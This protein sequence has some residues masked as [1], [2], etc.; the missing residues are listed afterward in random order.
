MMAS[1]QD[2]AERISRTEQRFAVGLLVLASG[3][4]VR[5]LGAGTSDNDIRLQAIWVLVY[6]IVGHLLLRT[7]T[8][9]KPTRVP[10]GIA[11]FGTIAVLSALW[12]ADPS[13]TIRRSFALLGTGLCAYYLA[14]RFSI[15]DLLKLVVTSCVVAAFITVTYSAIAGRAAYQE[16]SNLLRGAFIH[17]NSLGLTMSIGVLAA[18]MLI[19]PLR[20]I[21][22]R[23]L[24]PAVVFMGT[25][26]VVSGSKT[27]LMSLI[28]AVI[29]L[30][31]ASLHHSAD[32]S[33]LGS[34]LT[35][36]ALSAAVVTYQAIGGLDKFF[37]LLGRDETFT[38][39]SQLWHEVG[40]VIMQRPITGFGYNAFWDAASPAG[41]IR[42]VIGWS[43]THAHS[44]VREVLLEIGVVGLL[45]IMASM[46]GFA[47]LGLR[48][49]F[50]SE[51]AK[52]AVCL[53]FL[54][55]VIVEDLTE[56]VFPTS[57]SLTT[58]LFVAFYVRLQSINAGADE[59]A[60][61]LRTKSA[62]GCR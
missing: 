58:I 8:T 18:T 62:N 52:G 23:R 4:P 24:G 38:G 11:M 55:F 61:T 50:G 32:R 27:A 3:A 31:L 56:S 15:R 37:A 54:T 41:D 21:S 40:K 25:L 30:V 29:A 46:I 35:F 9:A 42:S 45:A 51:W 7:R 26:L 60:L 5:V 53:S 33:M 17:K 34:G 44:G 36:I 49:I 2:A 20:T 19:G 48:R 43:P 14:S 39:R 59:P 47:Y 1:N 57:N 16:G 10:L 22:L 13:L 6:V 12:S 28:V